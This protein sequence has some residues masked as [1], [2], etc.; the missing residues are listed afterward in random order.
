MLILPLIIFMYP[1]LIE[2]HRKS[3]VSLY[4]YLSL[5][6]NAMLS[7]SEYNISVLYST[8]KLIRSIHYSVILQ[9]A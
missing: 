5:I 2:I 6:R 4:E 7:D 9:D 1:I 3:D 8:Y